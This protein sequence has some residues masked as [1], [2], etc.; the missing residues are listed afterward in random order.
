MKKYKIY[1]YGTFYKQMYDNLRN[2]TCRIHGKTWMKKIKSLFM[3][4]SVN[5]M[6][7]LEQ[8]ANFSCKVSKRS[9]CEEIDAYYTKINDELQQQ[10]TIIKKMIKSTQ[11]E[12]VKIELL[13]EKE[14][15]KQRMKELKCKRLN[16]KEYDDKIMKIKQRE[17]YKVMK[18]RNV[19]LTDLE[20]LSIILYCE[21]NGF[22]DKMRESQREQ[23]LNSCEWRTLFG[24]L[25]SATNKIHASLHC[26]NHQFYQK[27]KDRFCHSIYR[28]LYGIS[29]NASYK[30]NVPFNTM[31]SFTDSFSVAKRFTHNKGMI[32]EISNAFRLIYE[33]KLKAAD[34][35][36]ISK[37]KAERE[38]IIL[39][40][41]FKIIYKVNE[42]NNG[43]IE[44]CEA[45]LK[46]DICDIL[47]CKM[48]RRLIDRLK[49]YCDEHKIL[50]HQNI[51]P[52]FI[53]GNDKYSHFG[54]DFFHLK[55]NHHDDIM[56]D[57][58]SNN[59]RIATKEQ[60][61]H[62]I[63]KKWLKQ[64]QQFIHFMD[65]IHGEQQDNKYIHN[66]TNELI[67]DFYDNINQIEPTIT[68]T[69]YPVICD[70]LNEFVKY[71][72]AFHY[73]VIE[74]QSSSSIQLPLQIDYWILPNKMGLGDIDLTFDREKELNIQ[75]NQQKSFINP[76]IAEYFPTHADMND[77][78]KQQSED[79]SAE[80]ASNYNIDNI[81]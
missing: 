16:K 78:E 48:L 70:P 39:P 42:M 55:C 77:D 61:E 38:W 54:S 6:H 3:D 51:L 31:T 35:S 49:H 28:G 64:I 37:Y 73:L 27:Y 30:N 50:E 59:L 60:T 36:W 7:I 8:L 34:V 74:L 76:D 43:S 11:S 47:T 44:L 21:N 12:T 52:D 32:I 79:S 58:D 62:W 2:K 65:M 57:N 24:Y 20:I 41:T 40:T 72:L 22:C 71:S 63:D 33:G 81:L 46:D 53:K 17:Q 4:L 25:H 19:E 9:L 18:S 69:L 75:S 67:T 45:H 80:Y 66:S 15:I 68:K 1:Q 13:K 10:M 5:H 23:Q 56:N 14:R 26:K 29:L